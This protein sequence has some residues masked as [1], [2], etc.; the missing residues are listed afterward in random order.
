M[1]INSIE[2]SKDQLV[3]NL[4]TSANITKIYLDELFFN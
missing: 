4:E 2:I 3:I 1:N